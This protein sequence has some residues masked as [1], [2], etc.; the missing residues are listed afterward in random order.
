MLCR[1]YKLSTD[2]SVQRVV[3]KDLVRPWEIADW[4]TPVRNPFVLALHPE[5]RQV[6][7]TIQMA[8]RDGTLTYFR[9][10]P[11]PMDVWFSP[12]ATVDRGGGDCDDFSLLA[13]SML[14]PMGIE[15]IMVIG[16]VNG[17]AHAWV[18]GRDS[19]GGFLIEATNGTVYRK[20]PKNYVVSHKLSRLAQA[21]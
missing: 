4:W 2:P 16:W 6:G 12:G 8:V 14:V 11:G 3:F 5:A 10:P 13:A 21:A 18:E 15:P 9:D 7:N 20:R 1:C 17:R 19:H